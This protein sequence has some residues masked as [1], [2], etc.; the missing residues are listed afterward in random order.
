MSRTDSLTAPDATRRARQWTNRSLP[1][2]LADLLAFVISLWMLPR[3]SAQFGE[4]FEFAGFFNSVLMGLFFLIFCVA[5]VGLKRLRPF[6]SGVTL[7][8]QVFERRVLGSLGVVFALAITMATAYVAG[9]LDS[10]VAINRGLLDEPSITIYLLL[11][12]ASWFG[13]ALIYMLVL[14]TEGEARMSPG[15]WSYGIVSFVGLLGVNL[16]GLAF[17]ATW[18][19]VWARF[20]DAQAGITVLVLNALLFLLLLGPP[21]LLYLSRARQLAAVVTFL[22]FILY[23]AVLSTPL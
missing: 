9:F 2:P 16:M 7:P 14:T 22:P 4:P 1:A 12:P 21:R 15:G 18:L 20:G 19:A 13:L 3:L 17:T 5:I 10:V 23:L 11:T 8:R 6:P